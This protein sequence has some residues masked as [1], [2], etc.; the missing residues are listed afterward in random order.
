V[1]S[2][3][4]NEASPESISKG[5]SIREEGRVNNTVTVRKFLIV[6]EA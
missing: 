5:S 2:R 3:R 1:G 4:V 6:L